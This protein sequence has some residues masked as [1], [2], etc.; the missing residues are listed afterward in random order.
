[1]VADY[2]PRHHLD[3]ITLNQLWQWQESDFLSFT[4][5]SP[6]RRAGYFGFMR[7]IAIALGNSKPKTQQ[8]KQEVVALLNTKLGQNAV[9]DEHIL[10]AIDE[11]YTDE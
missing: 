9:L 7:N 3:N 10:W 6:I 2:A 4:E 5:G 11:I 8:E 1:M